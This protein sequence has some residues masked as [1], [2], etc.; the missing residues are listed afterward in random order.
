MSRC[1]R[2]FTYL[3]ALLT[4]LLI[5]T[6][7]LYVSTFT[8]HVAVACYVLCSYLCE[9]GADK[10]IVFTWR[11]LAGQGL[12]I[13]FIVYLEHPAGEID[14]DDLETSTDLQMRAC[15]PPLPFWPFGSNACVHICV[16]L[17]CLGGCST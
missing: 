5:L 17:L 11:E 2:I 8:Y 10:D 9:Q 14:T 4:Y 3:S 6:V 7:S 12:W 15:S 16:V 1:Q 13:H